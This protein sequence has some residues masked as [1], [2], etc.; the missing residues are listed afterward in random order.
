LEASLE[1]SEGL[2]HDAF[3][4]IT[5]LEDRL[6]G[7]AAEHEALRL[8]TSRAEMDLSG[9]KAANEKL[10]EIVNR[11]SDS[12]RKLKAILASS[13]HGWMNYAIRQALDP[14]FS[15]SSVVAK[16]ATTQGDLVVLSV[17]SRD[18]VRV[19]HAFTIRR[20][21]TFVGRAEVRKLYKS[22]CY[23]ELDPEIRGV[24]APPKVGDTAESLGW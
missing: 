1:S 21:V 2:L 3:K 24:G 23:A 17:G 16:V 7:L 15:T 20:G 22:R 13:H 19:G 8:R 10:T 9:A 12:E 18:G 5:D 14:A 6:L 4:A 11:L